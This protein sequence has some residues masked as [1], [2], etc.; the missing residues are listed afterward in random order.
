MV[1]VI[2]WATVESRYDGVQRYRWRTSDGQ[3]HEAH[4]HVQNRL[5]YY[6]FGLR[7]EF[8]QTPPYDVTLKA[9]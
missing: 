7:D 1:T 6:H 5:P 4:S 2:G 8:G 3:V 9:K